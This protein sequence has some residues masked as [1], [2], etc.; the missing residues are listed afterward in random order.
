MKFV[1]LLTGLREHGFT[2]EMEVSWD[3]DSR[4]MREMRLNKYL[5]VSHEKALYLFHVKRF[6]LSQK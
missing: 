5:G 6:M 2:V 3:G 1:L 4:E